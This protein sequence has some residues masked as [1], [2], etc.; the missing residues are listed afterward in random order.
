MTRSESC[1]WTQ[2]GDPR[3][4]LPTHPDSL[5]CTPTQA[6][7]LAFS[8]SEMAASSL[9]RRIIPRKDAKGEWGGARKPPNSPPPLTKGRLAST[10][11]SER[12][13]NGKRPYGKLQ[14]IK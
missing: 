5:R 6:F 12:K 13:G 1:M 7:W 9:D 3:I 14:L 8:I 4:G 10:R 2:S 11:W